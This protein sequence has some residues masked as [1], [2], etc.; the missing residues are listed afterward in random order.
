MLYWV[1]RFSQ[2]HCVHLGFAIIIDE[3]MKLFKGGLNMTHMMKK[4]PIKEG[5]KFY[6]MVCTWSG[7]C[8]FF[9][10]N[11][12]K[13]KKKRG[14]V[15]AVVFMVHHLPDKKNT[16][17]VVV[18]DNYFTLVKTMIGTRKCGVAVIWVQYVLGTY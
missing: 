10:P 8:L 7:Y 2:T 4:K 14:I 5:F 18:M 15:D 9:F 1:N 16:Q 12:L 6:A 13:V 3:M 17:Y 11:G